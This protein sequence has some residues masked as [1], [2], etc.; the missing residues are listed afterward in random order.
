VRLYENNSPWRS[1]ERGQK[2]QRSC[3]SLC[4]ENSPV[5]RLRRLRWTGEARTGEARTA[6]RLVLG[7]PGQPQRFAGLG[8]V[9]LDEIV[10]AGAFFPFQLNFD[11]FERSALGAADQ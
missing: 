8:T 4:S 7:E 2:M 9:A 6:R 3:A 11:K 10:G 1:G 5:R